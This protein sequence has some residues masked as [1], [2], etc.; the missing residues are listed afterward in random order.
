MCFLYFCRKNPSDYDLHC[1]CLAQI[2]ERMFDSSGMQIGLRGGEAV[3]RL[4]WRH[5]PPP[6][7]ADSIA[8]VSEAPLPCAQSTGSSL[9]LVCHSP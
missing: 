9:Q 5:Y 1:L 8:T 6:A 7:P 3:T 4:C 2:I